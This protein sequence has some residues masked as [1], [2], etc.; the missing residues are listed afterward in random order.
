MKR[1]ISLLLAMTLLC[2]LC[3]GCNGDKQLANATPQQDPDAPC[4]LRVVTES[5]AA[6]C[7]YMDPGVSFLVDAIYNTINYYKSAHQNVDV[8][9]EI[10]PGTE[11]A[12]NARLQALR[13]EIM[14]GKGPDLFLLPAGR[15]SGEEGWEMPALFQNVEQAMQNGHFAD[16]SAFYDA[17]TELK[18]DELQRSIMDAGVVDGKRFIL[19]LGFDCSLFVGNG[20]KLDALDF[21]L[22]EAASNDLF[23]MYDA[24]LEHGDPSLAFG[25]WI[26]SGVLPNHFSHLFDFASERVNLSEDELLRYLNYQQKLTAQRINFQPNDNIGEVFSYC[27]ALQDGDEEVKFIYGEEC[28]FPMN[29]TRLSIIPDALGLAKYEKVDLVKEQ[30]RTTSGETLAKVTYW[31]AVNAASEVQAQAYELLRLFLMPEVQFQTGFGG[32]STRLKM[33]QRRIGWPV[34][35]AGSVQA[36]WKVARGAA[37]G[38]VA[39]ELVKIDLTDDELPFLSQPFDEVRFDYDLGWENRLLVQELAFSNFP[40]TDAQLE[41]AATKVLEELRYYLAES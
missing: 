23:F 35:V 37:S 28:N 20:G 3:A 9:L 36:Q 13:T 30:A 25:A 11:E 1:F 8:E 7:N 21:D 12:R 41:E 15:L 33:Q 32:L 14:A 4:T 22:T 10:L 26:G 2:A 29:G 31:G 17:D 19:P 27:R 39:S 40:A 6:S 38:E 5:T 18:T 34:R 16:L 24:V